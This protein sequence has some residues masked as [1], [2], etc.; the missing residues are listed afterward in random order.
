MSTPAGLLGSAP[1]VAFGAT[2]PEFASLKG[3][4]TVSLVLGFPIQVP[5]TRYSVTDF[6]QR[7]DLR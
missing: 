2:S 6:A 5:N 7:N 4:E 3:E 1:S